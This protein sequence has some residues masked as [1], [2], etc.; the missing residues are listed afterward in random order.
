M[1][2]G[3]DT[4]GAIQAEGVRTLLRQG[5]RLV[6]PCQ[7]LVR[8]PK[9]P[10]RPSGVATANYTR[11]LPMLEYRGVVLLGIVKGYT[12]CKVRVRRGDSTQP[13]QCCP[14]GTMRRQQHGSV[15]GVLRQ[16]EELLTEGVCSLVLGTHIII[17][18]PMVL[19]TDKPSNG[20]SI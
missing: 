16:G 17:T 20:M 5:Y 19:V 7:P 8:I 13:E 1:A 4:Q 15:L 12:L 3:S 11:L 9:R 6:V 2:E 10:E 14:Q 18:E